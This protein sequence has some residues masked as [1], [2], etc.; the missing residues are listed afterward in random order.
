[1]NR[2]GLTVWK[3]YDF[4]LQS[5]GTRGRQFITHDFYIPSIKYLIFLHW[6]LTANNHVPENYSYD[7]EGTRFTAC[8]STATPHLPPC[9]MQKKEDLW[10]YHTSYCQHELLRRKNAITAGIWGLNILQLASVTFR[11]V[12]ILIV[13]EVFWY[14]TVFIKICWRFV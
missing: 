8:P 2:S 3:F 11:S 4:V 7:W 9:H 5:T 10:Q 12:H 14:W 13:G 6:I 1:M